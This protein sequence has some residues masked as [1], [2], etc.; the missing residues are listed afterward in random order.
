MKISISTWPSRSSSVANIIGSP[1][2]VRMRF[3]CVISPPTVTHAPSG[4]DATLG[5]RAVDALAQQVAHLRERMAGEEDAERLLLHREQLDALELLGR[6][7]A[8]SAPPRGRREPPPAGVEVED[9]ALARQ[10][11]LLRL[12]ARGLRLRAARTS[13]PLRVA[14]VESS[15]PH[16]IRLSI[17][18]LFTVRQST[19]AQKS[20]IEVNG[21]AASRASRIFSTAA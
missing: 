10:R 7:A 21:A 19:R 3:A 2:F 20:Q 9:R 16:L 6:A 5:E 14:P 13:I 12:R 15:A 11:V 4:F 8:G 1:D 17:A 18:F